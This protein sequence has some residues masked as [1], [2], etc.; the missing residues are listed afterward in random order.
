MNVRMSSSSHRLHSKY[1]GLTIVLDG[2]DDR[3]LGRTIVK[4][5][6]VPKTNPKA[7]RIATGDYTRS[8]CH[9][10]RSLYVSSTQLATC[11]YRGICRGV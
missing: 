11:M 10:T 3:E 2:R 5:W 7:D 1:L 8:D 9:H 6:S 4:I